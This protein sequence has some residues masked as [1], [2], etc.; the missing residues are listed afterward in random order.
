MMECATDNETASIAM[1]AELRT[2]QSTDADC[3]IAFPYFQNQ[4]LLRSADSNE[5][6]VRVSALDGASQRVLPGSLHPRFLHI[7]HYSPLAGHS[8]E[9]RVYDSMRKKF[10]GSHKA[11]GVYTSLREFHYGVQ[12][13]TH[14]KR[15]LLLKLVLTKAPLQYKGINILQPLPKT[16]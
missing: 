3:H 5:V 4:K 8:G 14:G 16:K 6:L 10:Y 7:C 2:A 1:F 12:N 9:R 11:I 15:Q 13:R